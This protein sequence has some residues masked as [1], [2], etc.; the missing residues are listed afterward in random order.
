MGHLETIPAQSQRQPS[1]PGSSM[2]SPKGGGH[3]W[4]WLVILVVLGVGGWYIRKSFSSST[5]E[6]AAGSGRGGRGGRGQFNNG[7]IPVAVATVKLG[8]LPVYLNGLGTVT[9]LST[10]TIRSRVDGQL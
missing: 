1:E 3:W 8:D 5:P 2:T 7:P 6:A 10:V 4:I 9:P